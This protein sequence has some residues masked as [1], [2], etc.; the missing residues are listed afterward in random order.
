MKTNYKFWFIR[1]NDDGFITE[2]AVRF[3]EGDYQT[4]NGKEKY[5][6]TKRLNSFNELKHLAKNINGIYTINGF[7]DREENIN[8]DTAV[9]YYYEDFGKIK[10]DEELCKFLN[11]ELSKDSKRSPIKEQELK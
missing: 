10:T 4:V 9:L 1:R 11:K 8:G 2:V 7:V 6:M 5:V 3:Y